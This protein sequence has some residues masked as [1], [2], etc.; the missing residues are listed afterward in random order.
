MNK[1]KEIV[2]QENLIFHFGTSNSKSQTV[3]SSCGGDKNNL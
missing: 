1:T 3:I 2:L